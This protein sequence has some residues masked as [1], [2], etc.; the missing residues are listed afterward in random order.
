LQHQRGAHVTLLAIH[1]L[2]QPPTVGKGLLPHTSASTSASYKPPSTKDIPPVVLTNIPH[3]EPAAFTPYLSQVGPLY[4][5]IQRAHESDDIGGSQLVRHGRG[6]SKNEESLVSLGRISQ[7][8]P[9][10]NGSVSY[11]GSVSSPVVSPLESPTLKRGTS[12][13]ASRRLHP[14]TPLS[15]I[16]EV[17]FDQDFR[18]E[19]PRTF[20][21]VSERSEVVRP[22]LGSTGSDVKRTNG[23]VTAPGA[24]GRK[25][26]ATNAILQEK[27]SWYMDTVEVHL[28][29]SISTASTSFFAALGSLRELHSEVADSVAR[30][31]Q[32]RGDLATL[33][34]DLAL[35]G[36]KV[37]E[38]RR[39]LD[40]VRKLGDA[41]EQLR[42]IVDGVA[43]CEEQINKDEIETALE[44]LDGIER[45]MAGERNVP[46]KL[47]QSGEDLSDPGELHDLRNLKALE[48]ATDEL[49]LLR[50]KIGK[51]FEA[52]FLGALLADLRRHVASI[53]PK[54]TVERWGTASQRSRGEHSR[55]PSTL[56]AFLDLNDE[57]RRSSAS[58]LKGLT[59]SEHLMPA[60]TAYREAVVREIKG[61]IRRH[62][63]SS[64]DDDNESVMS[65]STQGGRAMSQ[66]EKS[67]ILARNLRAMDSED[68]E[69]M[70]M[71][72]YAA[73]GESLRRLGVQLKV[74]LDITSGILAPPA[75]SGL[76]SP[77]KSPMKPTLDSYMNAK[78]SESSSSINIQAEVHQAL[79]MSSLLGQA[80]D[81][82]QTQITKI[83]KV[84]SDQTTQLPLQNFLRYFA[85]NR[86]FADECEAV[87]GR[88]GTS[89][90]SVVNGHIKDFVTQFGEMERQR[91]VATM[92]SDRWDA[93]D[94]S[95][96][97]SGAL[98]RV[99]EGSTR[100]APEW[101]RDFKVW[102]DEKDEVGPTTVANSGQ[103][104][105][106]AASISGKDKVRSA[107]V[108]E[109]KY[110]LPQSA[111]SLLRGVESYEHL[112]AGIPS[113]TQDIASNLLEYLKLFNS[114]SAQ[115]ILGAGA[116]RSAGLKNITTKHLALASQALSFLTALIPYIR[117]SV[118][119]R[120]ST[121]GSIMGE[122]DKVKRLYQEHQAGIHEKLVDIMSGR[123]AMHVNA[124]KKI[125]WDEAS[126]K[127]EV[128]PYMETLTKETITLHKV[129][130]KHLPEMT[131]MMIMNPVFSS[132][133][134][135]WSTALREVAVKTEMGKERLEYHASV[136]GHWLTLNRLLRD[137]EFFKSKLSNV[138][139]A[140]DIGDYLLAIIKEKVPTAQAS[141]N[142]SHPPVSEATAPDK[143][144]LEKV[145][146]GTK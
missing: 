99:L 4:D 126:E 15:T 45:L 91:I 20:D 68:A 62:L 29:G 35:R 120:S 10:S 87:S 27:L 33:D 50:Y 36:L 129:L 57:L 34:Q 42:R 44:T 130:S 69:M 5:A 127:Q 83:L 108:D 145:E 85:L 117:E 104:N 8:R 23:S 146:Q 131:V 82:A 55:G 63:P 114:R 58:S 14:I 38:M 13:G 40:N 77:P 25:A 96:V 37:V 66:Q 16:P 31:K 98:S 53:H 11:V 119:R 123:A 135:Q 59:R 89:L 6:L 93:K 22:V 81:T 1:A 133:K 73:V 101:T 132:Y 80:V 72:I 71:K 65:A 138:D 67:L 28:I 54:T 95:D 56:L 116:T 52:Q 136:S 137:V 2:L 64:N 32:L 139:G 3:T 43:R 121:S 109:Q 88:G 124:M 79:D 61:I 140:G 122:F 103:A 75:T 26:L 7:Q 92:D 30:I 106:I 12:G 51:A 125:K 112:M 60:A 105:G 144:P 70:L 21:I 47:G 110:I 86:L 90:K 18:L 39:R 49:G 46:P 78:G 9:S 128:S 48:G 24:T 118:R 19:N 102:E 115:L 141:N 107:T 74:L 142:T 94:F 97:D 100:D 17:Y 84:R 41:V 76:R 134:E 113:M 143:S 111:I